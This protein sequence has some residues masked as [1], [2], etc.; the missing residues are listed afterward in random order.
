MTP[1][2]FEAV[3][4]IVYVSGD[5]I[6]FSSHYYIGSIARVSPAW[7]SSGANLCTSTGCLYLN[8]WLQRPY[9]GINSLFG[10]RKCTANP[11]DQC[12]RALREIAATQFGRLVVD[13]LSS[14]VQNLPSELLAFK[15]VSLFC[16][17]WLGQLTVCSNTK[18]H[19]VGS[20]RGQKRRIVSVHEAFSCPFWFYVVWSSACI[21]RLKSRYR[22]TNKLNS[23]RRSSFLKRQVGDLLCP[24][25]VISL[26]MYKKAS[27]RQPCLMTGAT[28][29][30][31]LS[32][33]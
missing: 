9:N 10:I 4:N 30:K 13:K 22:R 24:I 23:L 11:G 19:P 32:S 18:G 33:H 26:L 6:V 27:R 16:T 2:L 29:I 21:Y 17:G 15:W 28:P 31:Q 25:V 8:S 5:S 7:F 14:E 20:P 12:T 3:S 1:S